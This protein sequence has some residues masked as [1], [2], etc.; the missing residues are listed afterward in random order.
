M[1]IEEWDKTHIPGDCS[2][3][4]LIKPHDCKFTH[5]WIPNVII[6]ISTVIYLIVFINESIYLLYYLLPI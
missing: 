5:P 2:G 3:N 4:K 6:I 1:Y